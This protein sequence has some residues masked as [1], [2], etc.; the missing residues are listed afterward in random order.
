MAD[1]RRYGVVPLI[2][3]N[4]K[5]SVGEVNGFICKVA[6]RRKA[7]ASGEKMRVARADK[8]CTPAASNEG[9]ATSEERRATNEASETGGER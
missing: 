8:T 6:V 1:F 2:G 7:R 5:G 9:R 4:P 3:G